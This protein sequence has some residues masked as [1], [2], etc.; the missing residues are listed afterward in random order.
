MPFDQ[1]LDTWSA[2]CVIYELHSG[3]PLFP[4]KDSEELIYMIYELLGSPDESFVKQ[5]RNWEKFFTLTQEEPKQYKPIFE[6]SSTSSRNRLDA[7]N[8]DLCNQR[9]E[10]GIFSSSLACFHT[11][12]LYDL[13]KQF[14][15]AMIAWNPSDRV[16]PRNLSSHPF[17]VKIS[18]ITSEQELQEEQKALHTK[19]SEPSDSLHLANRVDEQNQ[20]TAQQQAVV[21]AEHQKTVQKQPQEG[22]EHHDSV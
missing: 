9:A 17:M 14:I 1:N 2:G 12:E 8:R 15:R 5:I 3:R 19:K 6:A 22:A 4:A 18:Q 11:P 10:S 21:A 16:H 20:E 13:F 7:F